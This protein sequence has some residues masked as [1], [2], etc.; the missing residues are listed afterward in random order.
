[1]HPRQIKARFFI[2]RGQDHPLQHR[3][4]NV[5]A[6]YDRHAFKGYDRSGLVVENSFGVASPLEQIVERAYGML[7]ARAYLHQYYKHGMEQHH[8]EE[9]LATMENILTSYQSLK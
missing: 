8:F 2:G 9:C 4:Q 5:P 1:M 7:D 3:T 6:I